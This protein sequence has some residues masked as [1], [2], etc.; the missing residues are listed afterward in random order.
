MIENK[1]VWEALIIG[2]LANE[3]Q[4]GDERKIKEWLDAS[5]AHRA[6]FQEI[7][8]AWFVG[9]L[10]ASRRK[11][12][13]DSAWRQFEDRIEKE[14]EGRK[15][16]FSK[17]TFFN[18]LLPF[19]AVLV[20]GFFLGFLATLNDWGNRT[21]ASLVMRTPKGSRSTITLSDGTT[22]HLNAASSM[23]LAPGFGKQERRVQLDGEAYFE[24]AKD[25]KRRFVVETGDAEVSV[26]GT[27]FNVRNYDETGKLAVNLLEG[28]VKLGVDGAEAIVLKPNE[29]AVLLKATKAITVNQRNAA[30]AIKWTEGKLIFDSMQFRE[31][32][33]IL[34]RNYNVEIQ[35]H[36]SQLD[37]RV[38]YGEFENG[39]TIEQ[40]LKVITADGSYRYVIKKNKID[41]YKR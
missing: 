32:S 33:A 18:R 6:Y 24:V 27:K 8:R 39:E 37:D 10:S 36:D 2:F 31:I 21:D 11:Y 30:D 29:E 20:M 7:E 41:I 35:V 19:A 34:E 9:D 3:L 15:S 16:Y 26:L 1:L 12:D 14:V 23:V 25:T 22:V 4:P 5:A 38:F 13:A 40:V 28:A 17:R